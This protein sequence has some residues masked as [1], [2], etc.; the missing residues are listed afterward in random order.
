MRK[1]Y[2]IGSVEVDGESIVMRAAVIGSNA[3]M[4]VT[5]D[6]KPVLFAIV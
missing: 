6:S 1:Y 4:C 5:N 2:H 3:S